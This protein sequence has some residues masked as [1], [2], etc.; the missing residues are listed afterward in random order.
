MKGLIVEVS[1]LDD[2]VGA[3]SWSPNGYGVF[4]YYP[5]FVDKGLELAPLVMP[6][7]TSKGRIYS[8][9]TNSGH[10]FL[11]LP[12]LISDALPD[13]Y[14]T[15]KIDAYLMARGIPMQEITPLDRLCYVGKRAMGAL[16]FEPADKTIGLDESSILDIEALADVAQEV[17]ARRDSFRSLLE[18]K[19]KRIIDILKVGTSAGGAKPKAI[20]AYNEA[21]GEVRSGQV[22]A[23][24]A[25]YGY[26]ILKFDGVGFQEHSEIHQDP[27]GIGQIEYAYYLMA[28]DCGIQM[29]ECRLLAEG[30][31]HHFMTRRFDRTAQGDKIHMQTLAAIAHFDRDRRHTY[32]QLFEVIRRLGLSYKENEQMYRRMVFNV[33][34]RNHDDHTKNHSFLMSQ[35]GKWSLSPAYDLCYSYNPNGRF[36]RCHQMYLNG[37]NTGHTQADLLEVGRKVGIMRPALI[38]EEIQEV[39]SNWKK[40]AHE[41]GVRDKFIREIESNLI[42]FTRG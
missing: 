40:Y 35:E 30:D 23:P 22:K 21:T 17:F 2:K 13:K 38:L 3:L 31:S 28:R 12:G 18:Q 8:F 33:L 4:E 9:P 16:E 5:K 36:T 10:C 39:V 1:L 25:D 11:G 15:E 37:K 34:S 7:A 14:G 6:L 20:I 26:W 24:T 42:L 41:A 29:N 27:R 32:E 19:D